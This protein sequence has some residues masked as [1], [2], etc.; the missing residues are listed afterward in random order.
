MMNRL[1]YSQPIKKTMRT[2]DKSRNVVVDSRIE[3]QTRPLPVSID[4]LLWC[5]KGFWLSEVR[6]AGLL[7][8][9][10]EIAGLR[11]HLDYAI[12]R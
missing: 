6:I 5:K 4:A 7:A 1:T 12:E 9:S 10:D 2:N 3:K 11:L 8:R